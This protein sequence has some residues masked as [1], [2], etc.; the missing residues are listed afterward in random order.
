ML[1]DPQEFDQKVYK[2]LLEVSGNN[3]QGLSVDGKCLRRSFDGEDKPVYLL[4]ALLHHEKIVI[5]QKQIPNKKNEISEFKTLLESLDLEGML[6]TADAMHCQE[7]HSRF[8]V[9]DKKADYL[10]TV[11]ENQPTLLRLITDA[12]SDDNQPIQ[13]TA[14][15]LTKGHGRIDSY[16]CET[17]PWTPDLTRLHSFPFISQIIKVTRTWSK[18]NGEAQK[19]EV[20]YQI[21]SS[22]Q[23]RADQLLTS[24]IDHW[25]I[26]NGAHYVRDETFGEDR[27]RVRS[28]NAPHIMATLRNLSI[29]VIRKAG[30]ENMAEGIRY[31]AWGKHNRAIRAIGVV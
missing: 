22:S 26:E 14:T 16:V 30:G 5:A 25:S 9:M 31:F 2:W 3:G 21:T 4:S 15:L 12:L 18:T 10:W 29:G 1:T 7:E 24:S 27:S 20:R 19:S 28:G 23:A 11:K 13:A 8:L 17:K 6:V